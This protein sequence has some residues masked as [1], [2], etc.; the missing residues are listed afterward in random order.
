MAEAKFIYY[1]PPPKR[2]DPNDWCATE[3]LSTARSMR[4]D[5]NGSLII[6][7]HSILKYSRENPPVWLAGATR[8]WL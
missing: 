8:R 4:R 5:K 7:E 6:E 2:P 1:E 3:H